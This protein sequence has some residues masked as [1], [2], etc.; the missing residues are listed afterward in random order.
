MVMAK[1]IPG[2]RFSSVIVILIILFATR[3][4]TVDLR[5]IAMKECRHHSLECPEDTENDNESAERILA[6]EC[7]QFVSHLSFLLV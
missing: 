3:T 4:L 6:H 5:A 7:E 1:P 2:Y